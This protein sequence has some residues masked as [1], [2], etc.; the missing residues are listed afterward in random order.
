MHK[1]KFLIDLDGV[2][3]QY[4]QEKFDENNIPE[5]K[6]GAKEFICELSQ[7][8]ELYLFTSRNLL[9]ASKWLIK[10]QID[11]YFKDVT[12]IKIPAYLCIDDRTIRFNGNYTKTLKEIK[13][14]QVYWKDKQ[15][16]E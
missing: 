9:L 2:L 3:N 5:I 10:N 12:N 11:K 8:A 4:G 13:S 1:K 6:P 14:F 16:I 15:N 7:N